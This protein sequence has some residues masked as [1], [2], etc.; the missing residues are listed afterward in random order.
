MTDNT[1]YLNSAKGIAGPGRPKGSVSAR[2]KLIQN[3]EELL[4][5]NEHK[6]TRD[7]QRLIDE[8]PAKFLKDYIYPV[9]P[10]DLK[11]SIDEDDPSN[12]EFTVRRISQHQETKSIEDAEILN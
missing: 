9:M 11:L 10:K 3:L 8:E 12:W 6:I 2:K 4:E 7:L 5:K 1:K